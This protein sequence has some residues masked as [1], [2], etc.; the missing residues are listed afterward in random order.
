MFDPSP[1]FDVV[2]LAASLGGLEALTAVLAP[3]PRDFPAAIL[4]VQHLSARYPSA[5]ADLLARRT[6]LPVA[7]AVHGEIIRPGGRLRRAARSPHAGHPTR[8]AHLVAGTPGAVHA[9]RG[10]PALCLRG[11]RVRRAGHRG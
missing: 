1:P 5:L 4:V 11:G 10:R 3:L 7:W 8:D 6:A 2:A 9:P